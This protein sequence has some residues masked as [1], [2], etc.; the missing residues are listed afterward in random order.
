[1]ITKEDGRVD[2]SRDAVGLERLV[3]GLNPWPSAYT[4]LNGKTLKIWKA[5]VSGAGPAAS[6]AETG[7]A[8]AAPFSP[9]VR[10]GVAPAAGVA[11]TKAEG[12]VPGTVTEVTRDWFTV[13]TG[14]G[15]LRILEVQLEGRKRMDVAAFLR[16][17]PLEEGARL[18]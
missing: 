13:Q 1:M 11:G 15:A 2:W 10:I 17:C 14:D 5:A 16:G 12:P 4:K 3:R 18:G 8:E 7:E 9:R 6:E